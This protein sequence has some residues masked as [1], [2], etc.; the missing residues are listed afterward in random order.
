MAAAPAVPLG[1]A[2]A[3]GTWQAPR[4]VATTATTAAG[5]GVI[6]NVKDTTRKAKD[7]LMQKLGEYNTKKDSKRKREEANQYEARRALEE[8]ERYY[9]RLEEIKLKALEK[10]EKKGN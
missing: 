2:R 1:A 4:T 7:S 8:K 10:K 5:P 3:S 9:A 6:D